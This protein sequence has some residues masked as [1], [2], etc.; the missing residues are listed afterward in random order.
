M[1]GTD[2]EARGPMRP[3]NARFAGVLRWRSFGAGEVFI[4]LFLLACQGDVWL[5]HTKFLLGVLTDFKSPRFCYHQGP[6]F[7]GTPNKAGGASWPLTICVAE[8]AGQNS[9]VTF[10]P[11]LV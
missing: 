6:V 3:L 9:R 11:L 7:G 1:G 4:D 8:I 5:H 2:D 10:P